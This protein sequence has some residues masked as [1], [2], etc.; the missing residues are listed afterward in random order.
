[1]SNSWW[2]WIAVGFLGQ[3]MFTSRFL[4]QWIASERKGESIFPIAF[5]YFSLGGGVLLLAYA[6][7]RLDPV[8][9]TGQALGVVVYTRNLMLVYKKERELRDLRG[10]VEGDRHILP[11][12]T[13]STADPLLREAG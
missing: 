9:I 7:S 1:M 10:V 2:F 11:L 12:P 13:E 3:A 5:W 6:I 8:I 4:V